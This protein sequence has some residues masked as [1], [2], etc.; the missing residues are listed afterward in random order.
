[1]ET[2]LFHDPLKD[3]K[4]TTAE[5]WVEAVNT[6]NRHREW[7]YC[8]VGKAAEINDVPEALSQAGTCTEAW[9]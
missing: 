1:L 9:E 8:M 5:R 7:C 6:D 2:K 4:G 3:I